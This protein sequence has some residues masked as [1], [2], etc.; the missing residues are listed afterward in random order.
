MLNA[1]ILTWLT[2]L[3]VLGAVVVLLLPRRG[4]APQI[5]SLLLTLFLFVLALHLPAH[6]NYQQ[7]HGFQFELNVPVGQQSRHPLS[8]RRRWPFHVA[9]SA[10][11]IPGAARRAD[12]LARDSGTQK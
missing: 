12:F 3:P 10:G 11:V 6:F 4:R 5:F 8:R 9:G 2:F 1:S 7:H